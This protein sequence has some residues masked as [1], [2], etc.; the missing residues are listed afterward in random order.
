MKL[1]RGLELSGTPAE[2]FSRV[3]DIYDA[4]RSLPE[5]EMSAVLEALAQVI[6]RHRRVVDVGVGTGRF[7]KPL[8]ERGF[9]VVGLDSS[10]GMMAKAREKGL[11]NLV[12]SDVERIPFRDGAFEAALLVHILHLV[13]RW[14]DVV[15]EA[16]RVSAGTVVAVI[17]DGDA[18]TVGQRYRELRRS[19]GYPIARLEEGEKG[20]RSAIAPDR[21]IT[22]VKV[23][24]AVD[25]GSEIDRLERREQ[26]AT[27]DVPEDVHARIIGRL[28]E[29][30]RGDPPRSTRWV[31]VDVWDAE[32]LRWE[33]PRLQPE[34]LK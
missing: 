17:E 25:A 7:A 13:G 3:A 33:L 8:Q 4:T 21:V 19:M 6:P 11:Q 16:A 31:E 18:K 29:E 12:Y 23:E 26:S 9:E 2:D 10:R 20:L 34:G 27:W 32:R 15:G 24:D 14:L 5:I 22:A 1:H 28:R 30:N